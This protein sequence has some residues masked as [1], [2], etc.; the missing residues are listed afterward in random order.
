MKMLINRYKRIDVLVIVLILFTYYFDS[1]FYNILKNHQIV[2]FLH[3]FYNVLILNLTLLYINH[4]NDFKKMHFSPRSAFYVG[5]FWVFTQLVFI[6]FD[7]VTEIK[8]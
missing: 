3:I 7:I 4:N 5:V 8:S 2:S 6:I 1:F